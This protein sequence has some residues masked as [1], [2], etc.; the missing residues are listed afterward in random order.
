MSLDHLSSSTLAESRRRG[1]FATHSSIRMS[2]A[3]E[4][5]DRYARALMARDFERW[6]ELWADDARSVVAYPLPGVPPVTCGRDAIVGSVRGLAHRVMAITFS[7]VHVHE[8]R[9]PGVFFAQYTQRID[10]AAD[11]PPYTNDICCKVTVADGQITEL[12]EYYDVERYGRF[13]ASLG[14][15]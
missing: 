14:L 4:F 11:L 12:V 9:T 10:L 13:V 8:T 2:S 3:T 7:D 5:W 1:E 6:G 15:S